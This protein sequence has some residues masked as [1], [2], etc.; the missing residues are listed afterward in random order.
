M[1]VRL[2]GSA[3]LVLNVSAAGFSS[4]LKP[5]PAIVFVPT[6]ITLIS[7]MF[8]PNSKAQP[9]VFVKLTPFRVSSSRSALN[10]TLPSPNTSTLFTYVTALPFTMILPLSNVAVTSTLKFSVGM[11]NLYDDTSAESANSFTALIASIPSSTG[12]FLLGACI[13]VPFSVAAAAKFLR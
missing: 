11:S 6:R 10:D 1:T 3:L 12:I 9:P 4:K 8:S 13:A 5:L 2:P 7:V